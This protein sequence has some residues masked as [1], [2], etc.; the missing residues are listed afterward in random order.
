M[1][2]RTS[3]KDEDLVSDLW[4]C[5]SLLASG[6]VVSVAILTMNFKIL[7]YSCQD[8]VWSQFSIVGEIRV[9]I[10]VLKHMTTDLK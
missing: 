5:V 2:T 3:L 4:T 8:S 7:I 9:H 1:A 10:G 6:L